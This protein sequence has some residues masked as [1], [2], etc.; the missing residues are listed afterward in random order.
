VSGDRW[1]A[2]AVALAAGAL[3]LLL[4]TA[5]FN[6]GLE[7]SRP[8]LVYDFFS[9][10][11]P[12]AA[13]GFA[14]LAAGDLP[15]WNPHHGLGGPFLASLQNGLLYPPNLLHLVLPTQA[16]F[17]ALA[18][19][20][21]VLAGCFAAV[22]ARSFGAG[23]VGAALAALLYACGYMNWTQVWTPPALYAAAWIPGVVAAIDRA[24]VR[25]SARSAAL[26]AL[27]LAAQILAGWPY[28]VLL[29]ALTATATGGA[30]LVARVRRPAEVGRALVAVAGGVVAGLLL[31]APLLVPAHELLGFSPRSLGALAAARFEGLDPAHDPRFFAQL[32]LRTGVT[33]AVPGWG[34]ALLALAALGLAPRRGMAVVL[35]GVG[36]LALAASFPG[37]TPVLDWLRGLPVLGDL[38]SPFRYRVLTLLALSVASGLALGRWELRRG[39]PRQVAAGLAIAAS[40][41]C[42]VPTGLVWSKAW[43]AHFPRARTEDERKDAARLAWL[44]EAAGR[45][46]RILWTHFGDDK[47]AQE[48]GLRTLN[49][50]EPLSLAATAR[51]VDFFWESPHAAPYSGKVG[52]PLDGRRA[53]LL[54]LMSVRF[55]AYADAPPWI[56]DR[57]R[58]IDEAPSG[59]APLYEN[60]HALPRAYRVTRAELEPAD[61][62]QALARL[63]DP[64][65][66]VQ[67]SVLLAPLPP[68][69]AAQRDDPGA[70]TS[71]EIDEPERV[72]VRTRGA[73]DAVLVL[74]DAFLPG[75]EATLD[76]AP[77]AVLRANTAVRAVV[78]PAGEH[79]VEMRYRPRSLPVGAA[80]A[81]IGAAALVAAL[82]AARRRRRR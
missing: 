29:T 71:I 13:Y 48:H 37:D 43:H 3:W 12:N 72:V 82:A 11:R 7:Q 15:L 54:D 19:A 60:P 68:G 66:D 65:F 64:S 53:V 61:P 5:P 30:A 39:R 1:L 36:A 59:A 58:R 79:R 55:V 56:A 41:A 38:R 49:D 42:L 74:T 27:A 9:Y 28:F 76:G 26:L 80:L 69:L 8:P 35:L 46:W 67:T 57:G 73:S 17:V 70:V 75:W 4:A 22:L 16:A 44:R 33:D 21:I 10:Y 63:V 20:H 52:L 32:L 45:E 31:A 18:W 25:P 47:L 50:L 2:G 51:L 77:V 34:S 81:C 6:P 40:L 62:E 14:R 78:V 24:I 23:P